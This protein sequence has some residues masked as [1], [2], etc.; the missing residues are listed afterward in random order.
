MVISRGRIGPK[1]HNQ[2]LQISYS[3]E[4]YEHCCVSCQLYAPLTRAPRLPSIEFLLQLK[5]TRTFDNF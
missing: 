3:A 2:C 1:E 5:R 4:L